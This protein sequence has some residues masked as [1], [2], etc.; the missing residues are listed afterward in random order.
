L[1]VL[2]EDIQEGSLANF[3]LNGKV[4]PLMICAGQQVTV[5]KVE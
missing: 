1:E 4:T 2:L 3:F 5:T